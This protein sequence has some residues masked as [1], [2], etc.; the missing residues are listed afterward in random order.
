MKVELNPQEIQMVISWFEEA[1]RGHFTMG[2][3][4]AGLTWEEEALVK[5]LRE[6]VKLP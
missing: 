6:A 2:D 1:T 4:S 3:D 5:K